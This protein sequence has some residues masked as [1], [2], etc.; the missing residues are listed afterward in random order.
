MRSGPPSIEADAIIFRAMFSSH[1]ARLPQVQRPAQAPARHHPQLV[2]ATL[3]PLVPRRP[4]PGS[5]VRRLTCI[6]SAFRAVVESPETHTARRARLMEG[7]GGWDDTF[8]TEFDRLRAGRI[9]GD[10][11]DRQDTV[12]ARKSFEPSEGGREP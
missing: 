11:P 12:V 5:P 10:R 3:G 8:R 7:G 1:S 9:P 2:A 6:T 4:R